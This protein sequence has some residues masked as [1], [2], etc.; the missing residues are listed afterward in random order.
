MLAD[1]AADDFT[2]LSAAVG[3][4]VLDEVV[5]ELVTSDCT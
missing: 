4:D 5:S 1:V 2:V 3:Q